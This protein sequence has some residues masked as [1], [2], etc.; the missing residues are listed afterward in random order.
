[1]TSSRVLLLPLLLLL[2]GSC[3]SGNSDHWTDLIPESTLALL[4]P[5]E[6]Q[7]VN[8]FMNAGFIPLL[9]DITPSAMQLVGGLQDYSNSSIRLEA[10]LLYPDTSIDFQPGWITRRQEGLLESIAS[11]YRREFDQ[12]Q[13][14]FGRFTIEKIFFEDRILFAFETDRYTIFSE[15]GILLESIIRTLEG[16]ESAMRFRAGDLTPGS[17]ILNSS[18]LDI[19]ARQLSLVTL[20]PYLHDLFEGLSSLALTRRSEQSGSWLW[21]LSGETA[22]GGTRSHLTRMISSAEHS[23]QLE[24]FLPVNSTAFSLMRSDPM[25]IE[26]DDTSPAS[27]ADQFLARNWSL[28]MRIA[29]ALGDEVA[30]AGFAESGPESSSEYLYMRSVRNL[31]AVRSALDELHSR[32]LVI[33]DGDT[34][35]LD[36]PFLGR[37]IGSELNPMTNFYLTLYDGALVLALR[38]GL[39]ESIGG[40]AGRRRVLFF[41]DDY[42]RMKN[43]LGRNFSSIHYVDAARFGRYILP[44]LYP[45]NYASTLLSQLDQFF[46]T[47][48]LDPERGTLT[49]RFTNFEQERTERPFREQWVFSTGNRELT[50]SPVLADISGNGRDEV[51]FTTLDGL[52]S[53]LAADGTAIVQI[54]TQQDRPIGSPVAYDWYGNNQNIIMQAAGNKV[55]AWNREGS[56]LPNFPVQL[57]EEITTPLTVADITGNGVAEMILATADRNVHIL[58]ARGQAISGWPQNTNSLVTSSPLISTL[59]GERSLFVFSENTL[60]G[61]QTNG[62][63][64]DGFPVF[65]PSQL[66]GAPVTSGSH[67][68]GAALDGSLYAVGSSPLFP[69]SLATTHRSDSF[70]VQSLQV[71]NSSLNAAPSEHS[72]LIRDQETGALITEPLI[73]LQASNGSLFLYNRNG[74]L[75]FT[76]S[77]GQPA[78][79][80]FA[81]L[82]T[83]INSD[84]RMDL[85]AL[86][87]FGRLYAW[88]I[89]SGQRHLDLPS[90]GMSFPVIEDFFRDGR[91]EVIAHTRSG[92]QNWTIHFTRREAEAFTE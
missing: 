24:R 86:A 14:R 41:D 50:A 49:V 90:T 52:V 92:I 78:S 45:Q 66:T 31:S 71:T 77:M 38:K 20:R 17:V 84:Q 12:N 42:L 7:S 58:N 22:L 80:Q 63:L 43:S 13:Y 37:L 33:R 68:L 51:I 79:G 57:A 26:I 25:R 30:F 11:R 34:Y 60:H 15:S 65:L 29:D 82:I 39:A 9:D 16:R 87:D 88:D 1:M 10:V 76:A 64:R 53:V 28:L 62:E 48:H 67:L 47:T 18:S 40:E 69:D 35:A 91:K 72:L 74:L 3:R 55:Y 32:D 4:L 85:V 21:Q 44:W 36:S 70:V 75:R 61:W 81:P 19:W 8:E 6:G 56:L 23:F 5:E 54:S 89:L 59:S 27:D 2:F 73:L 83:D 46:I